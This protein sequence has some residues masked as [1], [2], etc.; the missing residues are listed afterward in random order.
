[1]E[2]AEA[3]EA[4]GAGEVIID[5][6]PWVARATSKGVHGVAAI[7]NNQPPGYW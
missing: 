1:V 4:D 5:L 2:E 7:G 3:E 6:R